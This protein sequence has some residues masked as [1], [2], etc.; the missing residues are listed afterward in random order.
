[1]T[2]SEK[3]KLLWAKYEN[4]G[5]VGF[6]ALLIL[7]SLIFTNVYFYSVA[8]NCLIFTVLSFSLNLMTGYMGVTSLGHA[9]FFGIGAYATAILQTRFEVNQ[10]VALLAS[11][12][13]TSVAGILLSL[14]TMRVS[15]RF[16]AIVTLGFAEIV[17]MVELNW[18]DLTRGPQGIAN[19]PTFSFLGN[20]IK[21]MRMEFYIIMVISIIVLVLYSLLINSNHGR[22]IQAI[23][24]DEI[25]AA[26]MGINPLRYR[27]LVFAISAGT[28]GVA[29]CFYAKYMGF[30]DPNAFNFDQSISILSMTIFGGLGNLMGSIVGAFSLSILPEALR[31]LSDY[32]QVIYG[33]LLVIMMIFRPNGLLGGINFKQ[34]KLLDQQK[35]EELKKNGNNSK[36]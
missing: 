6:Y 32:R 21:D 10:W 31:F 28:A 4:W 20:P 27:V 5:Y 15:T 35:M 7:C 8:I 3:L 24:N 1:M 23:K 18:M 13:L 12:C 22:A 30:I 34:I 19:I 11:F 17:R 9:A 26:S 2:F 36:D 16:V 29:G 33:A 25:A 14:T